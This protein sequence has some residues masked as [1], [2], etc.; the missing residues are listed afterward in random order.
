MY[1][2][3]FIR[4]FYN[5]NEVYKKS[6]PEKT[7]ASKAKKVGYVLITRTFLV[8]SSLEMFSGT[9]IEVLLSIQ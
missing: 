8:R 2:I 9:V 1:Y 5:L 6:L 7:I 4:I 3:F